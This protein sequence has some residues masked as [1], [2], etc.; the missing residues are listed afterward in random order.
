[1]RKHT[2][3]LSLALPFLVVSVLAASNR[4]IQPQDTQLTVSE[5]VV[6]T[7][8]E[9]RS[10]VDDL[11]TV[12]SGIGRVYCWTRIS[13]AE[14]EL[15]IEHVWYMGD[16]EMGRIPLHVAGSNWRTWSSKNIEPNW[17][18]VWRVDVVGPDGAV[19]ESVSFT[20]G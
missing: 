3:M 1:M 6:T 9:D 2:A 8:V 20:V 5:A 13:G 7:A 10:P 18:G 16:E 12:S 4:P 11:A 14:G 15:E 19:L 17:T